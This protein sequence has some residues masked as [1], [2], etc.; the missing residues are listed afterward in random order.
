MTPLGNKL[1]EEITL[2]GITL[3]RR[4]TL[5]RFDDNSAGDTVDKLMLGNLMNSA[6]G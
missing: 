2:Q 4:D 6:G 5:L 3:W 1:V